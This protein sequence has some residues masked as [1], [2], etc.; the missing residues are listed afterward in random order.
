MSDPLLINFLQPKPVERYCPACL[1]TDCHEYISAR[2]SLDSHNISS[3]ARCASCYSLF[4]LNEAVDNYSNL[5]TGLSTLD[6]RAFLKHY[7]DVGAGPFLMVRA[8]LSADLGKLTSVADVGGG[9]GL[10]SDFVNRFIGQN[11]VAITFEPN[12]YGEVD[13]PHA[14]I[15]PMTLDDAWLD[16]ND[17][18]FDMVF[19]SEVIEHVN[20]PVLFLKCLGRAL[21]DGQSNLVLTTPD[22]SLINPG[23]RPCDIWTN[24][25]PG[26]HKIIY[27]QAGMGQVLHR[28]GL[29]HIA[30]VPGFGRLMVH[31]SQ[32]KKPSN[33]PVAIS[34]TEC[35]D[36]YVK[37]L[38]EIIEENPGTRDNPYVSGMAYRLF[39]ELVNMGHYERASA[40]LAGTP[41]LSSLLSQQ[42][43]G[44]DAAL[45]AKALSL[46]TFSSYVNACPSFLGPFV[47]YLA[48]LC[49]QREGMTIQSQKLFEQALNLLQHEYY[50]APIF[51]IE[52]ASLIP[53]CLRHLALHSAEL[54]GGQAC[55]HYWQ[56][57]LR[58]FL[59][60]NADE[61]E[62]LADWDEFIYLVMLLVQLNS[63]GLFTQA[64]PL[65]Q[66]M[67][68]GRYAALSQA[69]NS[70]DFN[71]YKI[72]AEHRRL[73]AD[74]HAC[75]IHYELGQKP[76]S[77]ECLKFHVK[78]SAEHILAFPDEINMNY[79]AASVARGIRRIMSISDPS[80]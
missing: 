54:D 73:F 9:V 4:L 43:V 75:M 1:S 32:N 17:R 5:T 42:Q 19:A 76:V 13:G 70:Q 23:I 21:I 10:A 56:R 31:A 34:T 67:H 63:K 14:T 58:F 35:L 80:K 55:F 59:P 78:I 45:M 66:V 72:P 74:F 2:N 77:M 64:K 57:S 79:V 26:E 39:K 38:E 62:S 52:S 49:R 44:I 11:D 47:F 6:W 69:W 30:F 8:I 41:A 16:E 51:F 48:M 71:V 53:V 46:S 18:R 20:D 33:N 36:I 3:Y 29:S 27:T 12:P 28:A 60:D 24:L 68:D 61:L 15:L 40:H 7:L 22:A 25:F 50:L 65:V 37:Y